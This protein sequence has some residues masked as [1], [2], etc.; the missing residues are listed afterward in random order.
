MRE[1]A[2]IEDEKQGY[3]VNVMRNLTNGA[4]VQNWR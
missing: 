2:K 4:R 3:W 1:L